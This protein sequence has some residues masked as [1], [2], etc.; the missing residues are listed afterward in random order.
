MKQRISATV[1][2]ETVK[3]VESIL[4]KGKYRNKSHIIEKA[5]EMM[6]EEEK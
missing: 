4:K 3:L 1:D 6:A 2:D 5:I